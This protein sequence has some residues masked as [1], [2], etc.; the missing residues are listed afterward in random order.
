MKIKKLWFLKNGKLKQTQ[1]NTF[2]KKAEPL[3]VNNGVGW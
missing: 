3:F 2:K 1:E